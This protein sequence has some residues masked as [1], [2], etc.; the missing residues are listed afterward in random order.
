MSNLK[1]FRKACKNIWQSNRLPL[2]P[3]S[4]FMSL[5]CIE[6]VFIEMNTG[7]SSVLFLLSLFCDRG[8]VSKPS[9][10]LN[11]H[12][13]CYAVWRQSYWWAYNLYFSG[14]VEVLLLRNRIVKWQL[15]KKIISKLPFSHPSP[16][17]LFDTYWE[18]N[19]SLSGT[20]GQM[21]QSRH[22]ATPNIIR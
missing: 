11:S 16:P 5:N 14:I 13:S 19:C 15:Q 6:P 22:N 17:M 12:R 1:P 10:C 18:T 9:G 7:I 2:A 21:L 4:M 8:V 20:T 3:F